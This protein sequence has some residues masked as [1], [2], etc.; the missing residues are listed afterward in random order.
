MDEILDLAA[1]VARGIP[2]LLANFGD[3]LALPRHFTRGEMPFGVARHVAGGKRELVT[4]D[5]DNVPTY[6]GQRRFHYGT[7]EEQDEVAAATGLVYTEF[8]G[9][10]VT[11]EVS[12]L[13]GNEGRL[14][15]TGQLGDVMKESA[16]AA[17]TFIRSRY[18][19][20]N[21]DED[22]YKKLDIHVHVPAGAIP[23]DGPSAGI[24]IATAL[25]S[26]LTK[27]PVRK[28]VAMTGEITLRGRVL[29]IGGLKEKV[30][31]AHRAGVETLI[32]PEQNRKD[33][34][35]DVPPE[36]REKLTVHFV[37]HGEQV[38]KLALE[39]GK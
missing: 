2:E 23:K 13:R 33:Y 14:V 21:L 37:K 30:L 4:I 12:L 25:A 15:L 8:G 36:I 35:E 11:V 3:R 31:A 38:L 26:A 17:M 34:M 5:S 18:K 22:F 20:L 24:T 10:I 7:M 27:R 28:D 9:D 39:R 16:Q 1:A 19:E 6:L 29:P 32:L